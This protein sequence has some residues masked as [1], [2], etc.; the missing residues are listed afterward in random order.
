MNVKFKLAALTMSLALSVAGFASPV[1][2]KVRDSAAHRA[3]VKQCNADYKTAEKEAR[4][5]KGKER[6]EAEAAARQA[7]K[8]CV[9]AAPR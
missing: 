9:A 5:K 3:A 4:T 1:K 6:K 2:T 8:Q 7:R